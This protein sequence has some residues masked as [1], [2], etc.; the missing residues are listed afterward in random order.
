M[1]IVFSKSKYFSFYILVIVVISTF[2]LKIFILI[3]IG[4]PGTPGLPGSG[5]QPSYQK[6]IS[7]NQYGNSSPYPGYPGTAGK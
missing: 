5:Y 1:S 3:L 7:S 4:Q 2:Y 6:P